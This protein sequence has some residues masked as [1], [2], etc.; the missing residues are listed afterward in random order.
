MIVA[1]RTGCAAV[2]RRTTRAGEARVIARLAG[3]SR[4]R[5]ANKQ[6]GAI[7]T[8]LAVGCGGAPARRAAAIAR[9]AAAS[10]EEL[11]GSTRRSD[12]VGIAGHSLRNK[13]VAKRPIADGGVERGQHGRLLVAVVDQDA[14]RHAQ[15]SDL[16]ASRAQPRRRRVRQ[17]CDKDVTDRHASE[18]GYRQ[19]DAGDIPGRHVFRP[20]ALHNELED[21][22]RR[23]RRRLHNND[24]VRR[25]RCV[26]SSTGNHVDG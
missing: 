10:H 3:S 25:R 16:Q 9:N 24:G 13:S 6:V 22:R 19:L 21:G 17:H 4:A 2:G 5:L 14:D 1:G 20:H 12:V 18:G 23:R 8:R 7:G 15:R 26:R 11:A